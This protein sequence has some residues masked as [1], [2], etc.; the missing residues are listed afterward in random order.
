MIHARRRYVPVPSPGLHCLAPVQRGGVRCRSDGSPRWGAGLRDKDSRWHNI[1][2]R[3]C[4]PHARRHLHSRICP[5]QRPDRQESARTGLA[6]RRARPGSVLSGHR[7]RD[8]RGRGVGRLFRF[9][10][11]SSPLCD[12]AAPGARCG[13]PCFPQPARSARSGATGAALDP[14]ADDPRCLALA[15]DRRR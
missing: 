11:P 7:T 13:C 5:C 6:T 9:H 4:L 12:R 14:R 2:I 1:Y 10:R 15:P 8:F 3:F